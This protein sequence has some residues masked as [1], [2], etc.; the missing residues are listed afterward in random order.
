[1][2]AIGVPVRVLVAAWLLL[3]TAA[4]ADA[5][6][7]S[8]LGV[9]IRDLSE[10]EMEDISRRHGIREGYGVVVVAVVEAS[11][12][13]RAGIQDGDIVVA[14]G[15]RPIVDSRTLQRLIALTPAGTT[16]QLTVLRRDGREPVSVELSEMPAP[17]VG[18]RVAFELGFYVREGVV[19]GERAGGVDGIERAA[20]V[21]DLQ[22]GG[23]ADR[24][25][26]QPGDVLVRV[27]DEPV[28]SFTTAVL[29]LARLP[30]DGPVRLVVARGPGERA[31]ITIEPP[32]PR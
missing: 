18:E 19:G 30:A 23:P 20:I 5:R 24:A 9:R 2:R 13:E 14:L 4:P 27:N 16:V 21:A 6:A 3:A 22:Q 31:T 28:G 32:A 7:W 1:V 8:W 17:V 25:G 11:P 10:Y 12:A 29:A 15:P 26:L